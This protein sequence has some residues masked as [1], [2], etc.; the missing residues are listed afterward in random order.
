MKRVALFLC[1]NFFCLSSGLQSEI[2]ETLQL[3]EI[4]TH[5]DEGAL[6]V[7]DIDNTIMEASHTLGSDQWYTY[8]LEALKKNG[9]SAEEA[10]EKA[11]ASWRDMQFQANM[12]LVESDTPTLIQQLQ[13]KGIALIALTTRGFEV[14]EPTMRPLHEWGIYMERTAPLKKDHEFSLGN[15]AVHYNKGILFTSGSHK[16]KALWALLEEANYYPKKIL[17]INDKHSHLIPV[18]ETLSEKAIPFVGFRY[19][20]TDERVNS[21]NA[22]IAEIQLEFY[23]K[24]LSDEAA[25]AILEARKKS[26]VSN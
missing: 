2:I 22:E 20:A 12:R 9:L 23:G 24:I 7:F 14:A 15:T 6:V 10:F 19:S 3:K 25:Q 13:E 21:F 5:V 17:F 26:T 4:L 8:R 1:L 16:G 18:E 11:L